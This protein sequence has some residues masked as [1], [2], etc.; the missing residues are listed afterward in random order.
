[1]CRDDDKVGEFLKRLIHTYGSD[2]G[3]MVHK[4]LSQGDITPAIR[5]KVRGA[6]V[7]SRRSGTC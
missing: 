7:G 6:L 4:A 1:M 5:R 3:T 2:Q